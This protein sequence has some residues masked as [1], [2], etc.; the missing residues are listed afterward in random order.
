MR[1]RVKAAVAAFLTLVLVVACGDS[2]LGDAPRT[3]SLNSDIPGW[4]LSRGGDWSG[5]D[6][7]LARW[8]GNQAGFKIRPFDT[9][10]QSREKLL[11]DGTVDIVTAT[12][13]ATDE[14]RKLIDFAG[15]YMVAQQALLVRTGDAAKLVA[16][17]TH[18]MTICTMAGST[19]E[20]QLTQNG[21][22]SYHAR[23]TITDCLDELHAGTVQ[24]ISTDDLILYGLSAAEPGKYKVLDD[25]IGGLEYYGIGLPK[26]HKKW[27]D[28]LSAELSDFITSG[29]WQSFLAKNLPD[30][31]MDQYRAH[32]PASIQP[33]ACA[34]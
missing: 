14:R 17:D 26:G 6:Y 10:T 22:T 1:K 2:Q 20:S 13:S 30:M 16:G 12:Y 28:Q 29:L 23:P 21:Y 19:S 32:S 11:R 15:P 27:C 5:F 33:F 9:L 34:D 3:V 31:P 4:G 8:L 7:D 25:R 24:S 18:A